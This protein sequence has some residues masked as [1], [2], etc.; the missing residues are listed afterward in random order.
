[1]ASAVADVVTVVAYRLSRRTKYVEER[2]SESAPAFVLEWDSEKLS[3]TSDSADKDPACIA[4]VPWLHVTGVWVSLRSHPERGL[5]LDIT[6][7]TSNRDC[8]LDFL[9][10]KASM[11]GPGG[12]FL[13][14]LQTSHAGR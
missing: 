7:E 3:L 12:E 10:V 8:A 13:N 4:A 2:S 5:H 1:M 11:D 9:S 14:C 6:L